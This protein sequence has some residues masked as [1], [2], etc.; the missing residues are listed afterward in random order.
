MDLQEILA[1]MPFAAKSGVELVSAN[2]GEVVGRLAWSEDVTTTDR[3]MHGGALTTL[4]DTVG[5]VS[6]YLNIPSGASRVTTASNA[7][8]AR[9]VRRG[10]VTGTARPLHVGR[11]TVL[12]S[13][14]IMDEEGRLVSQVTQSHAVLGE[15][16]P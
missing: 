5:A 1:T 3:I 12:V 2:A 16:G 11:K 13:I 6:A 4:A 15:L 7:V 8:F 9:Q 14:D 10:V